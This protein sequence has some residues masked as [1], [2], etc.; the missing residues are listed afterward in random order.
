[1]PKKDQDGDEDE[2]ENE[3]EQKFRLMIRNGVYPYTYMSK[4]SG[5]KETK[6]PFKKGFYNDLNDEEIIIVKQA[7]ILWNN[8][9]RSEQITD[10]WFLLEFH[11]D[12]EK[13]NHKA[14][15]LFTDTDSLMMEIE[16]ADIYKD[17]SVNKKK[18][19][20]CQ[21][22]AKLVSFTIRPIKRYWPGLFERWNKW[23]TYT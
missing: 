13:D 8:Y 14:K 17:I 10:V 22:M 11:H 19:L 3:Y 12:K 18:S 23:N 4:F 15:L 7:Y 6:W 20:I 9:F 5:L 2:N 1:M 21:I 16:T